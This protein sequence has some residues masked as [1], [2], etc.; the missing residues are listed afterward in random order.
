MWLTQLFSAN[1]FPVLNTAFLQDSLNGWV[2]GL[3]ELYFTHDGGQ[4]WKHTDTLGGGGYSFNSLRFSGS[5]I[6][7]GAG[8]DWN[9]DS[10]FVT[11][12]TDGG[13]TWQRVLTGFTESFYGMTTQDDLHVWAVGRGGVIAMTSDGGS[14]WSRNILPHKIRNYSRIV[15][16]GKNNGWIA[17]DYGAIIRFWTNSTPNGITSDPS[18]VPASFQLEQNYPNPFNPETIIK[19]T[20]SARQEVTLKVFDILGKEVATLIN[21]IQDPRLKS[22]NWNTKGFAGGVYYYRLSSKSFSVTKKMILV[23]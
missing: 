20:V 11:K 1:T 3:G 2:G 21:G 5:S 10:G 22:V 6:G 13:N 17:G 8:Y 9:Y 16:S 15:F 19:F 7:W 18:L 12:T 14:T 4:S 23:K